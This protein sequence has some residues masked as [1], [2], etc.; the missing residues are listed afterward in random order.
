MVLGPVSWKNV[1][2]AG[3]YWTDTFVGQ[4]DK[5]WQRLEIKCNDSAL[6]SGP[7]SSEILGGSLNFGAWQ[8]SNSEHIINSNFEL[9][10]EG[11][12][13]TLKES[14]EKSL[15]CCHQ[16]NITITRECSVPLPPTSW[17]Y[18]KPWV[19]FVALCN[20]P[21]FGALL[22]L[23]PIERIRAKHREVHDWTGS[24]RLPCRGGTQSGPN[25]Q[26]NLAPRSPGI[27]AKLIA[28]L[29]SYLNQELK[30]TLNSIIASGLYLPDCQNKDSLPASLMSHMN[31]ELNTK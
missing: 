12:L 13:H 16:T 18:K 27:T 6:N 14:L 24:I 23:L 5:C 11:L 2:Q 15:F 29:Q 21:A 22:C 31:S 4:S 3:K 10:V 8:I 25:H 19:P 17:G 1:K 20:C 28:K 30:A 7:N 9:Q 26:S